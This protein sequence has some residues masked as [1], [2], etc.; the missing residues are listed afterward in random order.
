M[1]DFKK[2]RGISIQSVVSDPNNIIDGDVWYINNTDKSSVN[3]R[4]Y[5][6]ILS[7]SAGGA[8]GTARCSL[9]GA[10]TNTAALAFGGRIAGG[11]NGTCTESYNGSVWTAG[12]DMGTAR[13]YLSGAGASN[14]AALAFGGYRENTPLTCTESYQFGKH[15]S[16]LRK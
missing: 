1:S 9:A 4:L 7:W 12:G 16:F 14:T 5:S 2:L 6:S 11:V 10:G 15:F 3:L 8:M 13:R